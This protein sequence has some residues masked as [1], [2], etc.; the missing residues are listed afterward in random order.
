[1]SGKAFHHSVRRLTS[2]SS[3]EIKSRRLFLLTLP[4]SLPLWLSA[5]VAVGM[6][7]CLRKLV[8]PVVNFWN[9]PPKHRAG[10]YGYGYSD[11]ART[12]YNIVRLETEERNKAA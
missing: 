10:Y 8:K 5:L 3:W 1:M 4:V 7:A 9:E 2:P 11:S 12:T 6:L